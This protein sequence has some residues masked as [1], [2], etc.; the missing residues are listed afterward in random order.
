MPL[1][2]PHM[3]LETSR[4]AATIVILGLRFSHTIYALPPP[5]CLEIQPSCSRT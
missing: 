4:L 5:Q 1:T 2:R 3:P